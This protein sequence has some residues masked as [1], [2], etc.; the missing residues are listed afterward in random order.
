MRVLKHD[1][2]DRT[3]R[4]CKEDESTRNLCNWVKCCGVNCFD[5]NVKEYIEES[6]RRFPNGLTYDEAFEFLDG[7]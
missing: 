1:K 2:D 4:L 3:V 6:E 7:K 5:C